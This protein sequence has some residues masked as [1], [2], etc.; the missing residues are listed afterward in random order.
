LRGFR[1]AANAGI[2]VDARVDEGATRVRR[3]GRVGG[4]ERDVRVALSGALTVTAAVLADITSAIEQAAPLA[5]LDSR[6]GGASP[7]LTVVLHAAEGVTFL[8]ALGHA[9]RGGVVV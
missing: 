5:D 9:V 7:A 2:A 3:Q 4:K 6:R 1:V 8:G